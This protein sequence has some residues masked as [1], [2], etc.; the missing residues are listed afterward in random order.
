MISSRAF[1][2]ERQWAQ[3]FKDKMCLHELGLILG[4]C[5]AAPSL[6]SSLPTKSSESVP[7]FS[8]MSRRIRASRSVEVQMF[9]A[10]FGA[11]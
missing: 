9:L 8:F 3:G 2:Y 7:H 6:K 10:R 11:G 5:S 1:L 4:M